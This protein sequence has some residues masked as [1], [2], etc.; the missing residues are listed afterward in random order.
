MATSEREKNTDI[1]KQYMASC[2]SCGWTG[3]LEVNNSFL[4]ELS[5]YDQERGVQTAK[6]YL[7]LLQLDMVSLHEL[8]SKNCLNQSITISP[9]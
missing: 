1:I 9:K 7:E 4:L 2:S 5:V 8:E 6:V 3:E